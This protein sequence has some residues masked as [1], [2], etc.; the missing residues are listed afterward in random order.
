VLIVKNY[1]GDGSTSVLPAERRGALGRNAKWSWL[2]MTSPI[3]T[4]HKP[5]G[6][7][8]TLFV[9]KIAGYLAERGASFATVA[10]AARKVA[11][12]TVS[13]ACR[14]V[15]ARCPESG[16]KIALPVGKAELG[17]GIHG[18]PG[19][20]LVDFA[21]AHGLPRMLSKM[22]FERVWPRRPLC[23][24]AQQSRRH[25]GPREWRARQRIADRSLWRKIKL[26]VGPQRS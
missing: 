6:V 19:V 2:A 10:N 24:S 9:H 14:S 4:Y 7:A 22:L 13:S 11:K 1:T 20:H 23:A 5:R 15:R 8:G 18:E 21:G 26:I 17:L 12:A 3:P 25:H 16:R